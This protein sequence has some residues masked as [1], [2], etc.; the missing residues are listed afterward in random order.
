MWEIEDVGPV[1]G[2]RSRVRVGRSFGISIQLGLVLQAA[3]VM[4]AE[5][6][7]AKLRSCERAMKAACSTERRQ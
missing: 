3:V 7:L 2:R 1:D 6:L 5:K 4:V